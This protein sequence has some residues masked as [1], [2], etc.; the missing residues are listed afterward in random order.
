M[1]EVIILCGLFGAFI[2]GSFTIGLSFGVKLR[3]NEKIEIPNLNPVKAVKKAVKESKQERENEKE[4]TLFEI[5][6]A[7]IDSY[8]GTGFGQKELPR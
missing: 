4:K 3:N 1:T 7:N 6:M 2:L 5:E 8:D